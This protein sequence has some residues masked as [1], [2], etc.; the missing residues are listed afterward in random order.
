MRS[1]VQGSCP[2]HVHST[3]AD[4][5][6][7]AAAYPPVNPTQPAAPQPGYENKPPTYPDQGMEAYPMKKY[8]P[9]T[10]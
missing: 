2:P 4:F 10:D 1:W 9:Q 6:T 5:P 7:T 8:P 3:T